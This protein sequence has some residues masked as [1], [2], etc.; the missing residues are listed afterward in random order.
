MLLLQAGFESHRCGNENGASIVPGVTSPQIEVG[1]LVPATL[2]GPQLNDP[3]SIVG[4]IL[5]P[6]SY[7]KETVFDHKHRRALNDVG[8][9]HGAGP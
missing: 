7:D 2:V 8:H 3:T 6:P 1:P 5:P 4:S 9:V